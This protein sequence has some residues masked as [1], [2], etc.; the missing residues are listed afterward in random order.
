MFPR[1]P[2]PTL[3]AGRK[4]SSYGFPMSSSCECQKKT[5]ATTNGWRTDRTVPLR[6]RKVRAGF[7]HALLM[8]GF[9]F[10]SLPAPRGEKYAF[11]IPVSD[12]YS[13]L[14]YPVSAIR[15]ASLTC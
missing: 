7:R 8:P 4:F 6:R 5:N 2:V 9:V 11:S 13:L 3:L 15:G 12:L 14:V 1:A 10:V